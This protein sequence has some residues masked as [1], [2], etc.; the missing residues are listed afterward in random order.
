MLVVGPNTIYTEQP[1][2]GTEGSS[3]GHNFGQ[4]AR[5]ITR[6]TLEAPGLSRRGTSDRWSEREIGEQPHNELIGIPTIVDDGAV[7]GIVEQ[8]GIS[9]NSGHAPSFAKRIGVGHAERDVLQSLVSIELIQA[10]LR[11]VAETP[12]R[13]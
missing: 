8:T 9:A 7:F 5:Q 6:D 12:R 11:S 3:P 2:G 4:H 13:Q 10:T 1:F